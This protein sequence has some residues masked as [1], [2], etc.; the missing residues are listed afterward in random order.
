M[1]G[2]EK[3][4]RGQRQREDLGS[5]WEA[6]SQGLL[7]GLRDWRA[8]HPRATLAEIE[9]EL[10]RRWNAFRAQLLADLAL[11]SEA[12]VVTEG[13]R[14]T[15]PECGGRMTSAGSRTRTVRTLGNEAVPLTRAYA[16]CPACGSGFFPP[17]P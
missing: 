1:T 15:C 14:P 9:A 4:A 12:A 7:L 10:D 16:T 6:S 17:G 11:A 13:E 2:S 5:G 3:R 8:L